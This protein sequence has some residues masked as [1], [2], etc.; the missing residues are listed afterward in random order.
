[1]QCGTTE[2]YTCIE[3]YIF[4]WYMQTDFCLDYH[5][6]G[7]LKVQ[8]RQWYYN[9]F[10]LLC[11]ILHCCDEYLNISDWGPT[12]YKGGSEKYSYVYTGIVRLNVVGLVVWFL[13]LL[14]GNCIVSTQ[15]WNSLHRNPQIW[16]TDTDLSFVMGEEGQHWK[17]PQLEH[18]ILHVAFI[19]VEW[20]DCIT[21][22]LL[23]TTN[24]LFSYWNS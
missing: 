23:Y 16:Y 4:C 8:N 21:V 1:V 24:A 14:I 18:I 13:M 9:S 5:M 2:K 20:S 15:L 22:K 12:I 19:H 3:T 6:R 7:T 17:T 10:Y 11:H